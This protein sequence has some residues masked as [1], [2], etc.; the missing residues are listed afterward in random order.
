MAD[1]SAGEPLLRGGQRLA[2][3]IYGDDSEEA[4]RR[5][6]NEADQWPVW[7]MNRG[8]PYYGLS[9]RIQAAKA[10]RSAEKEAQIA[11]AAA[12]GLSAP[13]A[14]KPRRRVRSKAT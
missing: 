8:G 5:F 1:Q 9:S 7:K 10:A 11:M 12:K 3:E 14:A 13:K 2:L 6:Y 4:V